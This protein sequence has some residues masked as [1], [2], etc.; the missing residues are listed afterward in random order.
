MEQI[1]SDFVKI[2]KYIPYFETI[3]IAGFCRWEGGKTPGDHS[4]TMP[5]PVYEE[6]LLQF[7]DDASNSSLMD[8]GYTET[9]QDYRIEPNSELIEQIDIAD[10]AF[11]RAVLT[12]YIRQERFCD[13]LWETAVKGGIFLALLKRL[14]TLLTES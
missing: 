1:I 9:I 10:L 13:G 8:Y 6:K 12:Y 4:F 7:I 11:T 3:D 5:Y 2:C 14:R